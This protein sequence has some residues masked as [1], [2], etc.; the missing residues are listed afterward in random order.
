MAAE[1]VA[2]A[3]MAM[4][5]PNVRQRVAA[6]E[7]GALGTLELTS[8]EQALV[9][10]ATPVLPDDHPSQVLVAH[11]PGEVEAHSLKPG[12]DSG[13]WPNGTAQAIEYV[14]AE[15]A[16][17]EVQAHFLSWVKQGENKFP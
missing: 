10:G 11:E 15:L 8:E 3:L 13:Y 16:D 17:P 6:G 14:Q 12:E 9:S 2:Q 7:F 4:D 1:D 5:D